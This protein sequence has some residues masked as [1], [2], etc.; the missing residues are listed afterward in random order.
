VIIEKI[1]PQHVVEFHGI[2]E[3]LSW[4]S[5]FAQSPALISFLGK[6][7]SLLLTGISINP[8]QHLQTTNVF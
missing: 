4:S 1:K 2:G 3:V 8:G 5:H 6:D 7:L